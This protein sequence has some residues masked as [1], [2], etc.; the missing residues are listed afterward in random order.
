MKARRHHVLIS[1]RWPLRLCGLVLLLATAA[2]GPEA[3]GTDAAQADPASRL[4]LETRADSIAM[5]AYE[6]FGGPEAWSALPY[7]QFDFAIDRGDGRELV[8]QHLWNRQT[9]AYRLDWP[10]GA[11][12]AYTVLFNVRS[13]EGQAYLN[14]TPLDSAQNAD[15]LQQAYY[16]FINDTY[17][18]LAPTKL[19]DAGVNR[20]YVPD[21]STAETDVL[22]LSFGDVGLTPG[23]Q[24]W[25]YVDRTSGRLAE[26]AFVLE[27]QEDPTPRRFAWTAYDTLGAPTGNVYPAA[28]KDAA[29]APVRIFT[30][31]IRV[32][33]EVD[34]E[35]FTRPDPPPEAS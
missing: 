26:W 6:A 31:Q 18:L 12:S 22:H 2:C 3:P 29:G 16:R 1:G 14:G 10:A 7:L 34:E 20:A 19:F 23:D 11:D 5:R 15:V 4:V 8:A 17:W 9:G 33:A 24:Y 35:S 32:P 21:S 13:R 30:D 25:L 27:G 28:R